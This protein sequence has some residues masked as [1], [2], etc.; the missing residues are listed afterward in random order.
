MRNKM[1][2]L[3]YSIALGFIIFLIVSYQL[4]LK[5]TEL[6]NL[7][8]TGVYLQYHS[9]NQNTI[10]T[11]YFD[12]IFK[13]NT[14][15]ISEFSYIPPDAKNINEA[16]INRFSSVDKAKIEKIGSN[17]YGVQP[18]IFE[19]TLPEFIKPHYTTGSGLALGD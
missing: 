12:A 9:G 8:N 18:N 19:A 5:S 4:Q 10:K 13:K 2:S 16:Q 11:E 7:A 3:I 17:V 14:D 15:I 1:T 6:Q